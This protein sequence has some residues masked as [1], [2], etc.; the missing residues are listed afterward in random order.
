MIVM[1]FKSYHS[2]YQ[3]H[4]V[5]S[6]KELVSTTPHSLPPSSE[7][8]LPMSPFI[9]FTPPL[10]SLLIYHVSL[11]SSAHMPPLHLHHPLLYLLLPSSPVP[12][13]H[14]S[15]SCELR[16]WSPIFCSRDRSMTSL[17]LLH[18]ISIDGTFFFFLAYGPSDPVAYP[19]TVS[20]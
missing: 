1:L 6:P 9:F 12:V 15:G 13:H 20:K 5:R 3:T 4:V 11:P 14:A 8:I 19:N 2:V 17:L 18:W 16:V 10:F 7:L